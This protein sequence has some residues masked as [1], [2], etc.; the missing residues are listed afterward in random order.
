MTA[1]GIATRFLTAKLVVRIR[2][3]HGNVRAL[4][5]RVELSPVSDAWR[6][7]D[8]AAFLISPSWVSAVKPSSRP[9]SST[10]LPLITFSTVVPV[11]CILRPVAA[12]RPPIRKS[13]K[14]GPVWVTPPSP[15]TNDVVA[16]GDQICRAKEIEIG[17]CGAEIGHE[18]L[19]V[20]ATAAGFMQRVLE[21]HVRRGDLIDDSEIDAL[22]PEFGKPATDNSLVVFLLAHWNGS[23]W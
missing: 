19:D 18:R 20:V 13:L 14:A 22:A 9:I 10:I 21:Q 7:F 1:R 3:V 16:F 11:K 15:L 6:R 12:G 5:C 4:F 2:P 8:Q 23:S 17:E